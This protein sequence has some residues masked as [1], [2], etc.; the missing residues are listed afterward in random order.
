MAIPPPA[1][2][3]FED[4][5]SMSYDEL[6]DLVSTRVQRFLQSIGRGQESLEETQAAVPRP[7]PPV[8]AGTETTAPAVGEVVE[9]TPEEV[10]DLEAGGLGPLAGGAPFT[11]RT[12]VEAARRALER[13]RSA[14]EKEKE[15]I[16]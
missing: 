5:E 11:P 10:E 15:E 12:R 16:I 4:Y 7:A 14:R 8:P 2:T 1:P 6:K 3:P 9:T 13:Q